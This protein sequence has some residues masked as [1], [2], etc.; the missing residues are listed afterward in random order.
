MN[1]ENGVFEQL[2][3]MDINHMKHGSGYL[4]NKCYGNEKEPC[5]TFTRSPFNY[6]MYHGNTECHHGKRVKGIG[7]REI[8]EITAS[9]EIQEMNY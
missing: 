8:L 6:K 7:D 1:P 3:N 9:N 4:K 5:F 2:M